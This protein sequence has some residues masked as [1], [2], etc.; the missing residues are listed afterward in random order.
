MALESWQLY[1]IIG[2]SAVA[3]IVILILIF[4]GGDDEISPAVLV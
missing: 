2:G 1:A 4:S 3:L